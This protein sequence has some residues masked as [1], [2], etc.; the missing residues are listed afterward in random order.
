[1]ILALTMLDCVLTLIGVK[2][3]GIAYE[4]NPFCATLINTSPLLF[5]VVKLAIATTL[6]LALLVCKNRRYKKFSYLLVNAVYVVVVALN[7]ATLTMI[8]CV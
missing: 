6:T 5:I 4:A 2:M 1:M 3:I 7:C 8:G